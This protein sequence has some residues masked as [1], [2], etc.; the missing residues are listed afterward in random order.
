MRERGVPAVIFLAT[1]Y[2]GTGQPFIGTSRP[3]CLLPRPARADI[4]LIGST[5][6]TTDEDRDAA[7]AAWV[8]AMKRLPGVNGPGP[9]ETFRLLLRCRLPD[10][11]RFVI[12]TWIGPTFRTLPAM[13]SNWVPAAIPF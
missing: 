11:M 1:D 10:Q 3:T 7:T 5:N 8:D 2:I 4:P 12:F 9:S 6:L 13:A